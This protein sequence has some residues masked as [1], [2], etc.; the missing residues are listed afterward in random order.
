MCGMLGK[1]LAECT[2][3]ARNVVSM[4]YRNC[5]V[6]ESFK[7]AKPYTSDWAAGGGTLALLANN[8]TNDDMITGVH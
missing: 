2:V 8:D 4:S 6:V 3:A 5:T 7:L 1:G